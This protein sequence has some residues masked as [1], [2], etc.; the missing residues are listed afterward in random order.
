MLHLRRLLRAADDGNHVEAQFVEHVQHLH[1]R[2]GSHADVANLP[3]V[4][5]LLGLCNDIR[6]SRLHLHEHNGAQV[7]RPR[8]DVNVAVS[9]APVALNNLVS[10]VAQ[11]VGSQVFAPFSRVVMLC[12][13]VRFAGKGTAIWRDD[14]ASRLVFV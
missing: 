11:I 10:R 4:Y 9:V 14:K 6:S 1:I 7:G 5:S 13:V 12:H 3:S 8:Y 2:V